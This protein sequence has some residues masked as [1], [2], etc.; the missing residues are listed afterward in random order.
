MRFLALAALTAMVGDGA[1]AA[2]TASTASFDCAKAATP[3]EKLICSDAVLGAADAGLAALYK[4]IVAAHPDYAA[5]LRDGQRA[6]LA[7]RTP[8]LTG[9]HEAQIACV[10][11]RYQQRMSELQGPGLVACAKPKLAGAAFT[12]TCIAPN[13]PLKLTLTLT[14]KKTDSDAVL[15][16]LM[17]AK[18]GGAPQTF[19]LADS[20]IFFDSL[21]SAVEAM[22]VNF[23]GFEDV[24]LA[25][26]TSAGPNM[27]YDYWLYV[28][29]TGQFTATTLGEQLSGFD[30]VPDA[31]TK[32]ITVTGRSSCCSWNSTTYAWRG[33][34]LH[35]TQLSDTMS[36]TPVALP[37][38]DASATLCG[39][40]TKHFNEAGLMTRVD[41]ELDS[42]KDFA[43]GGDAICEKPALV[44][45]GKLLD[46]LKASAK[47]FRVDAKDAYRF[48]VT[49]DTP[50]KD[51]D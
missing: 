26:S 32:T 23:D 45:Q 51:G 48:T 15:T 17:I 18:T 44:A 43:P 13:S 22:D 35:A 1:A 9:N 19:K 2:G 27:G 6:F 21:T 40:Q 34:K 10:K 33:S 16:A 5:G 50:R 20:Q 12:M 49:F 4:T 37:G 39:S 8:C 28:P 42:V 31:K 41:F 46:K 11:Q 30:V 3:V 14:G 29:K 47:G 24:K 25:T 36:F 7:T 38:F